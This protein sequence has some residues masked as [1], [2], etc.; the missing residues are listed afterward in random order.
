MENKNVNGVPYTPAS[1]IWCCSISLRSLEIFLRAAFIREHCISCEK[2]TWVNGFVW[3]ELKTKMDSSNKAQ[4][5]D[6]KYLWIHCFNCSE[7]YVLKRKKLFLLECKH[8][9]CEKC[10]RKV[11][12]LRVICPTCK[13]PARYFVINNEMPASV[14]KFF[15]PRPY[16][17]KMSMDWNVIGFQQSCHRRLIHRLL[18]VVSLK[19]FLIF[20]N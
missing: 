3:F 7:F 6:R 14:K 11:D 13:K 8:I 2:T 16:S 1:Q 20:G 9:S 19:M 18:A 17:N 5:F 12:D 4:T 10:L 15:N